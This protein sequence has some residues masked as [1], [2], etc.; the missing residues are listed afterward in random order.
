MILRLLCAL[1]LTILFSANHA[2]AQCTPDLTITSPGIYPDSATGLPAGT[3][4]VPYSEVIQLKVPLDTVFL[5]QQVQITNI[6]ITGVSGLPPGVTYACNPSNCVFPGG[7]NACVLLSGTPT[8]AGVFNMNVDLEANGTIIGVPLPP[9][10][11]NVDYYFITINSSTGLDLQ[12]S[13]LKFELLPNKP[14]PATTYTDIM[15][16]SPVGGDFT[17]KLY[18]MIGKEVY[19]QLFRG[20]AGLN[21]WR[22]ETANLNPGIYMISMEHGSDIV[23][24]RMIVSKK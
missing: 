3:V 15:F 12:L 20:M 13:S 21:T 14:N 2:T 4:G 19:T 11:M 22:I 23:T 16:T 10:S 17:V 7:S 18:N 24:R 5:G 1:L 8:V 6:T 9:Q